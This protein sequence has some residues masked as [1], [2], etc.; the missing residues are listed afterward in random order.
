MRTIALALT[1]ILI[2]II[3]IE[4]KEAPMSRFIAARLPGAKL[5]PNQIDLVLHAAILIASM[6]VLVVAALVSRGL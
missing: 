1:T 3:E 4:P 2:N 6:A 5:T